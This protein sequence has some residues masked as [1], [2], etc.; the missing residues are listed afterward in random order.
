[1]IED[2][3]LKEL[4]SLANFFKQRNRDSEGITN[5]LNKVV[6]VLEGIQTTLTGIEGLLQDIDRNLHL[7]FNRVL[8]GIFH[9]T[10]N[11]MVPIQPGNTPKFLVTPT[12]S[13][14]AFTLVAA[15]ASISSSDTTNFP[16]ALDPSDPQG[17]TFDAPIP[18]TAVI[19]TGGESVTVTWKYTNTDGT[20]ATVTGTVSEQGIVDD[21]TGGTFAQ[22]A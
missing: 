9:Q 7:Q 19:P 18:A 16:V 4:S 3:I 20:T 13:G 5:S 2:S 11:P 12:F 1:M 14:A 6:T 8:G 22:I 10:G 15:Q 17:L 21:V